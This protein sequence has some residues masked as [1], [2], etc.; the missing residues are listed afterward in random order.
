MGVVAEIERKLARKRCVLEADAVPELRTS[1]MTH[2]V[3]APPKWLGRAKA[4]LAGLAERHPSRTILLVPLPGRTP[5]VE[6]D[7]T[8][9]DFEVAGGREVLSEVIEVRLRGVSKAAVA[10]HLSAQSESSLILA[11]GDER[12]DGDLFRGL[13]ASSVR[14]SI[15]AGR[16]RYLEVEDHRAVRELLRSLLPASA[17]PDALT[18]IR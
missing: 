10:A 7:V 18:A 5:S 11:V 2:M 6:A 4:V 14:V 15:G 12:F 9:R 16:G 13:P 3:W 1:T 8:V 17:W